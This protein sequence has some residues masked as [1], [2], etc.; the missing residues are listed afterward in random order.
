MERSEDL[1]ESLLERG[2]PEAKADPAQSDVREHGVGLEVVGQ[3]RTDHESACR[4]RHAPYAQWTVRETGERSRKLVH[5]G[6]IVV[7]EKIPA[8]RFAVL[9]EMYQRAGAVVDVNGRYPRPGLPKLQHTAARNDRLDGAL[10]KPGAFAV[11]P[12]P[13]GCDDRHVG[14]QVF[15]HALDLL[16]S[17]E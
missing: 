10:A 5:L 4:R 6:R 11:D 12:P 16:S 17:A 1:L 14:D 2:I 9:G 8:A 3:H 15:D 13:Q 7:D